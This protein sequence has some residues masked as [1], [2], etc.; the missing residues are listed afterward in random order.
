MNINA[1]AFTP[2][3]AETIGENETAQLLLAPD[4]SRGRLRVAASEFVFPGTVAA[5]AAPTQTVPQPLSPTTAA[6]VPSVV[7]V[8]LCR[9]FAQGV[10]RKGLDCPF[11]HDSDSALKSGRWRS[12]ADESEEKSLSR[13][14]LE[15]EVDDGI[16]CCFGPGVEVIRLDLGSRLPAATSTSSTVII[17]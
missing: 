8:P 2:E 7:S 17:T 9:F 5:A 1:K 3:T 12:E 13:T 11:L 15:Y 10:C 4:R 16:A 14:T 6:F